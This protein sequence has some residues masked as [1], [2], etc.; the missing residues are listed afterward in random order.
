MGPPTARGVIGPPTARGV[1]GPPTARG[2]M[3]PPTARRPIGPPTARVVMGP[4]TARGVVGSPVGGEGAGRGGRRRARFLFRLLL[5]A[6]LQRP[7]ERP[8]TVP[9]AAAVSRNTP[10]WPAM[11]SK[12]LA[13]SPRSQ[14]MS[15]SVSARR[16]GRLT[17]RS[18]AD[19]RIALFFATAFWKATVV[20]DNPWSDSA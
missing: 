17:I 7:P 16:M 19:W 13:F 8:G 6:M 18:D 15:A 12:L 1:M 2:V 10:G 14:V 4:P 9:R 3:G 11:A 20:W 5:V